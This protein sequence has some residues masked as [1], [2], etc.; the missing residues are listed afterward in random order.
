[1][2]TVLPVWIRFAAAPKPGQKRLFVENADSKKCSVKIYKGSDKLRAVTFEDGNLEATAHGNC[3]WWPQQPEDRDKPYWVK[4]SNGVFLRT[5][6]PARLR[7][8]PD[9]LEVNLW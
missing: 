4:L 8:E 5:T 3:S 1:M 6:L 7:C 9:F 2:K